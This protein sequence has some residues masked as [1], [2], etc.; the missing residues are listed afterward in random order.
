MLLIIPSIFI[1]SHVN[2]FYIAPYTICVVCR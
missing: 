1:F 2:S